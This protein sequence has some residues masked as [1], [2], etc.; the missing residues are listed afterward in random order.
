MCF[1]KLS[2]IIENH[3]LWA[4]IWMAKFTYFWK[5]P[6]I[7]DGYNYSDPLVVEKLDNLLSASYLQVTVMRKLCIW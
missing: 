5:L 3:A 4:I 1:V 6:Y 7:F 2:Q